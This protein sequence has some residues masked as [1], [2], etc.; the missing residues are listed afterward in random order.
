MDKVRITSEFDRTADFILYE[1]ECLDLLSRI[2][3]GFVKL[4]V[5]LA[6]CNLGGPCLPVELI[7]GGR[8][9][10]RS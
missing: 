7:Q 9:G 4:V 5:T 3:D 1:G 6:P 2:P 10:K 8:Y